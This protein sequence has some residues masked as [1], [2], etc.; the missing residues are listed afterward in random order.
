[1]SNKSYLAK[2]AANILPLSDADEVSQALKE[3]Y[4]TDGIHDH[5]VATET[6]EL[7]DH[8]DIRYHF[9]IKNKHTD[10]ILWVGSSC[11]LRFGIAVYEDKILLD[12]LQ[13]KKKLNQLTRQ[14]QYDSCIRALDKLAKTE[15]NDILSNALKYYKTHD[16]LSP[17]YAAVIFW[18]LNVNKIDYH[19]SF[20]KVGL[21]RDKHK[22]DLRKMETRKV[23]AIWGALT[24]AQRKFALK[25]GHRPPTN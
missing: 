5:E 11:I 14:M 12:D 20:F 15:K 16:Y 1:M 17:K 3:W 8:E 9:Q 18:R 25:C 6:C 4:F 23:H 10:N 21:R 2:V 19:P 24:A 22:S 7:C 13:A